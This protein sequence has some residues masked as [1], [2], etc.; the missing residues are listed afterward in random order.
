MNWDAVNRFQKCFD[1]GESVK[2]RIWN[3]GIREIF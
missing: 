2:H 1:E 3:N